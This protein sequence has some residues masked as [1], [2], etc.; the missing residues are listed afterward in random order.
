MAIYKKKK[1]KNLFYV[2]IVFKILENMHCV[3][4][5]S[6]HYRAGGAGLWCPECLM[7]QESITMHLGV[8]YLKHNQIVYFCPSLSLVITE[9]GG[10]KLQSVR[11]S[12][13]SAYHVDSRTNQRCVEA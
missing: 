11:K 6:V 12:V 4:P 1:K 13:I 2:F 5:V 8:P 3:Y 9:H 7:C 10:Y